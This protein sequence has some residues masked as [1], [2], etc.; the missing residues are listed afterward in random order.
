MFNIS[1]DTEFYVDMRHSD[2]KNIDYYCVIMKVKDI[3]IIVAFLSAS[4]Y[5]NIVSKNTSN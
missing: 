1:L 2:K 4:Q 5:E 3:E